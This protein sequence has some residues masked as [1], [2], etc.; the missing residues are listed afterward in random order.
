MYSSS[1]MKRARDFLLFL[2]LGVFGFAWALGPVPVTGLPGTGQ[3]LA[4]SDTGNG[5][6]WGRGAGR[7]IIYRMNNQAQY[8][9]LTFGIVAGTAPTLAFDG[10]VNVAGETM[11]YN[12]GQSSPANGVAVFTGMAVLQFA[13]GAAF[14]VPTRF[15]MTLSR[16][17]GQAI[18]LVFEGG[19]VN[20]GGSVHN[21]GDVR[22]TLL[23]QMQNLS[24]WGGDNSYRPVLELYDSLP[25][26]FGSDP[27]TNTGPVM[28]GVTTGFYYVNAVTGMTLEQHDAHLTAE[29]NVVKADLGTLKTKVGFIHEDWTL[30]WNGI[31]G[32]VGAVEQTLNNTIRPTLDQVRDQVNQLI[33]MHQGG[34]G[35][36]NL[37]TKDDVN[38]AAKGAQEMLMIALGVMPCPADKAPPGFCTNFGSLWKLGNDTTQLR[39]DTNQILIGLSSATDSLAGKASQSSVDGLNG[40]L[41]GLSSGLNGLATQGSVTTL[42]NKVSDLQNA[43]DEIQATLDNT[44]S[45]SLDVRAVQV[46]SGDPKKLRWIVKT[47]R[48]GTL[49]NASLTR[50][51][52]VR[53]YSAM[54]NVMGNAVVTSLGTGLHDVVLSVSKEAPEGVAYLFEAKIVGPS[55]I[56]GS[57]LVVTEK[58]GASPF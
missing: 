38:N 30:R 39:L 46:D 58:K 2:A 20:P 24:T 15:Q 26:I 33:T 48:D 47:T 45:Q 14:S 40:I 54:S 21:V 19:G 13:N 41:I 37:A 51:A 28:T 52:T 25:T 5:Q 57:A 7:T 53:G 34:Q 12:S 55:D 50:F 9:A 43:I 29:M 17:T 31:Q 22:V 3:E 35:P 27:S 6:A 49:V 8:S 56:V 44:A 36:T 11:S 1:S 32:Q 16:V 10:G 42:S 18:P 4:D 23:F